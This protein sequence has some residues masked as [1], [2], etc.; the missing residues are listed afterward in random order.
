LRE[1][2]IQI[3]F[4]TALLNN[5]KLIASDSRQELPYSLIEEYEKAHQNDTTNSYPFLILNIPSP[6]SRRN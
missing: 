4:R 5:A 2:G 3:A 1:E 6:K